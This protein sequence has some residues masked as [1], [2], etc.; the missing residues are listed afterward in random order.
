MVIVRQ[1]RAAALLL[2]LRRAAQQS[3]RAKIGVRFVKRLG[4]EG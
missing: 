1:P 4:G 2:V 3:P